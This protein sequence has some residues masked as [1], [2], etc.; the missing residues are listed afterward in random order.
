MDRTL[1]CTTLIQTATVSLNQTEKMNPPKFDRVEDMADL[2]YLN[3]ASVLHNLRQRYFSNMIYV[4]WGVVICELIRP[5]DTQSLIT[6]P[7]QVSFS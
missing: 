1:Y 7:T 3:E 4:S 5:Y 6:R 2:S